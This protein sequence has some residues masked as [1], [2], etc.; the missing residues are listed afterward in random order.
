MCK[1][2]D[3][4]GNILQVLF[5]TKKKETYEYKHHFSQLLNFGKAAYMAFQIISRHE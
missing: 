1:Y 3:K 2:V 5:V 4:K